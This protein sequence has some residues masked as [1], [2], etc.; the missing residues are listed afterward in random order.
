MNKLKVHEYTR[1]VLPWYVNESLDDKDSA[2][3]LT[4]LADCSD[5]QRDR[6]QLYELQKLVRESD[7]PTA[8]ADLSF[9]RVM[10]RI[11]TAEENERSL[12]DVT[13]LIRSNH[14]LSRWSVA[15]AAGML[16]LVGIGV[17]GGK[18]ASVAVAQFSTLSSDAVIRGE[19]K[20]LEIGFV[21]PIPAM[22]LREALIETRSDLI[23][24]PDAQGNY[25]LEVVVPGDVAPDNYLHRIRQIEGV[26]HASFAAR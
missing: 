26:A 11:E 19:I 1:S 5:C 8:N 7:P 12:G 6:D 9:R 2:R 10:N 22:T 24:G 20:R 3:V 14:Y 17:L 21:S 18:D 23:S 13:H 4:H 16:L 25:L 15:V